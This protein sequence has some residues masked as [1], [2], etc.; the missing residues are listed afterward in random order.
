MSMDEQ[1][2][3]LDKYLSMGN[4][5]E[6][7]KTYADLYLAVFYPRAIGKP[8]WYV[9]GDTTT[10]YKRKVL[11]GNKPF[12]LNNDNVITVSEFVKFNSIAKI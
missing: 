3:L 7:Y 2:D 8:L 1:L 9:L 12:D 10:Q 11:K 6:Y 5:C 4:Y